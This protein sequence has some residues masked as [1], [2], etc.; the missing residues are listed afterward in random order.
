[1][2]RCTIEGCGRPHKGRGYCEHHWQKFRKYGDPLAGTDRGDYGSRKAFLE[3]AVAHQGDECMIWPFALGGSGY[4]NFTENG[5]GT[6]TNRYVC[7]RAHG[8][9]PTPKHDAAHSCRNR[10]CVTPKHLSWKTRTD[11]MADQL[12]DGTRVQGERQGQAKLTADQV[13]EIRRM[14]ERATRAEIAEQ[15]GV[16]ATNIDK[17][18]NRQSWRHVI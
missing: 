13:R 14:A 11:N 16:C 7:E 17:I 18:V 15:F 5:R 3:S 12:R 4:G 1:M 9:A 6:T 10:A 8:P 2:R